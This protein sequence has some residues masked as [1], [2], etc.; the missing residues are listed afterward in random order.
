MNRT[1]QPQRCGALP[2][3]TNPPDA[4]YFGLN[5]PERKSVRGSLHKPRIQWG[6]PHA[7]LWVHAAVPEVEAVNARATDG[8]G[9]K[10]LKP[11]CSVICKTRR[12]RSRQTWARTP[13]APASRR[14]TD[15]SEPGAAGQRPRRDPATRGLTLLGDRRSGRVLPELQPTRAARPCRVQ[16]QISAAKHQFVT[17][18]AEF[19]DGGFDLFQSELALGQILMRKTYH[20]SPCRRAHCSH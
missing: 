10:G 15:T 19:I 12:S 8:A 2:V 16:G 1:V 20:L 17:D 4:T 18:K 11:L 13:W 14:A 3:R 7:G 5:F 9:A 6:G